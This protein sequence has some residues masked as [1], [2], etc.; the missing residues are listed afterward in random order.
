[1]STT[2]RAPQCT[3]NDYQYDYV[4]MLSQSLTLYCFLLFP[5]LCIHTS[6]VREFTLILLIV[7]S[8]SLFFFYDSS[9]FAILIFSLHVSLFFFL[10]D[11]APTEISP[12]P[13]HDPLPI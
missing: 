5:V 10:N 2:C 7:F 13:L 9:S 4:T 6:Y 1:M 8:F 3:T 11:P 12:F